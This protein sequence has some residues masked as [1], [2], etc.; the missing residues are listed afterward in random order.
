[1]VL[2]AVRRQE[3]EFRLVDI[4]RTCPG[5]GRD[6]IRK[7]LADLRESGEIVC[8]GMGPAARWRRKGSKRSMPK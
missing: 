2:S 4:E 7:L 6:W 1:M 3:S 8:R 5:V